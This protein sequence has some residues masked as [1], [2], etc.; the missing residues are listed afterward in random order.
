MN[1]LTPPPEASQRLPHLM[2]SVGFAIWQ[3]QEL[4]NTAAAYVV[5]RLRETRGVGA[6]R[7]SEVAAQ[8]ERRTLGSL[9]SE[10][11][12]AGV[13]PEEL[14]VGLT[15]LL[16]ERNWLVHSARRETRGALSDEA[17]FGDLIV[18]LEMT[19]D[20]ALTL[21]IQLARVIDEFVRQTGVSPA[22]LDAEAERL[23]RSWGFE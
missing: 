4:E 13:V 20:R 6:E 8:V 7:G 18:R 19:A 9:I 1:P 23:A 10:L 17:R 15:E 11:R 5:V 22:L 14:A 12:K 21:T 2:C 3:L 16:H